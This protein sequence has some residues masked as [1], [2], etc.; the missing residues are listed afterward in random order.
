MDE[1]ALVR[2]IAPILAEGLRRG[3]AVATVQH[4]DLSPPD[5]TGVVVL[6][7]DLSVVS[8][9]APAERWL[10]EIAGEWPSGFDVPVAVIAAAARVI[11]PDVDGP[12]DSAVARLPT[13]NGRW[14]NVQASHLRGTGQDQVVV[15]LQPATTHEVSSM[16]L[17]AHGLTPASS[18]SPRSS[19]RGARPQ[20][21]SPPSTSRRTPCR[22]TSAPSST[23][24][25]SAAAASSSPLSPDPVA[26]SRFGGGQTDVVSSWHDDEAQRRTVAAPLQRRASGGASSSC[27]RRER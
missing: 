3:I 19:S 6:G 7:A 14:I 23:A 12:V 22:S 26:T 11:A 27:R 25:A 20:R 24:S 18:A 5:G 1:I 21:S 10:E 13:K 9:N 8:I 16:V 2:R 17:A 4:G 15:L